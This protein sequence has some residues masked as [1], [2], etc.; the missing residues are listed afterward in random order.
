MTKVVV[1]FLWVNIA[2]LLPYK[3]GQTVCNYQNYNIAE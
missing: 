3:T 1:A 2:I